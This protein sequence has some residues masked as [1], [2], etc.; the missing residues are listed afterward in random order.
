MR[1]TATETS[2][3]HLRAPQPAPPN[4]GRHR[5]LWVLLLLT[6]WKACVESV[7]W[8]VLGAQAGPAIDKS[9][10]HLAAIG[11]LSGRLQ[12]IPQGFERLSGEVDSLEK[13]QTT[14]AQKVDDMASRV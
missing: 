12:F 10:Q 14:A 6:W 1:W 9:E 4:R 2:P 11:G 5:N 8:E 7:T 13:A 3:S